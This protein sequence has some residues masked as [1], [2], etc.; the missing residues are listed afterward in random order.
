M[1]WRFCLFITIL[2]AGWCKAGAQELPLTHF[3]SDSEVNA[4]PSALVTNI[5]QDRQGYV[6]F[7]V[8]TSG[9]VRYDGSK[10]ELYDQSNGLR[11]LGIWQM[12]EDH[13][14][15]LWV[16]SGGGLVVSEK[17]LQEYTIGKKVKFTPLFKGMLLTKEAVTGNQQLALDAAGCVWLGTTDKGII[18]YHIDEDAGITADTMSTKAAGLQNLAVNSLSSAGKGGIIAGLEGGLLVE[19]KEDKAGILYGSRAEME[20][21]NFHAIHED[22]TGSIW[23]YRQNGDILYFKNRSSS[24]KIILS[25]LPS[26]VMHLSSLKDGTLLAGNGESGITRIN[27]KTGNIINSYS[28]SNGL[29]SNNVYHIL[30]DKEGNVWIAQSGGVSK[31]RYNF[32]AFENF[33][34][35]SVA[36]EKPVLP[37]GK[38]NAVLISETEESPCRFWVGTEGG[39]TCINQYGSSKFFTQADGLMGD[40]VNGLSIDSNG[41]IW[42]ATTQGINAIVFKKELIIEE[43]FNVRSLDIFG[44][45]AFIFSIWDS[46]GFIASENL[47]L[48][49]KKKNL[50]KESIWFPGMK[51]LY[52]FTEGKI[53]EFGP[54]QG[55]P[56]TL[57]KSVTM[58]DTGYLWVGTRDR[59]LYR[60]MQPVLQ[61]NLETISRSENN[62]FEQVWSLD[63]GAPTNHIEKLLWHKEKLWAGTQQGLFMLDPDSLKILNQINA[64]KGLPADN[65]VSFAVSPITQNFWIGTNKGLAEVVPENGKVL[66]VVTRQDG[67]IENEVWLYGSVK[68]DKTGKIYYGT[69][70]G[71]SI[72]S[73][74]KDKPNAVPPQLQLTLAEISYKSD[75]RNEVNFEYAALS[76]ANVADVKYRTRLLGYDN[77]WSPPSAVKRLR[78]TNLPA[79]LFPKEY[80]LE[81]TAEN[82]SGV[83][84]VEPLRHKFVV[85]PVW[86]LQW[87]AFLL[88]AI[89]FG[90][91]IF[92]VDRI[93]RR[94]LI[95]RERDNARLREAELQAEAA[96]ARSNASESQALALQAENEKKA[97][98]LEKVRELEK[99]Y[100]ELKTTQKQLI[101]A[102]KMAS[103]GRLAT[104]V[105]HEIKNPLNF[106]NNFAELSSELVQELEEARKTGDEEEIKFLM[107]DLKQNSKKIEEH[108]KRADAI[109]RSM[110]QHARG[111]KP[112]LEWFNINNL[113]EKYTDL[114]YQGKR[115]QYKGF[116]AH[117]IMNLDENIDEIK[118]VGQEIGQVLLNVIGNSLDAVLEKKKSY[119]GN[120]EPMVRIT[121]RKAGS[122]VEIIIE[123]NGPGIPEDIREKIF[124]PFF[125]TKPTGEGTGLGLSLSYNIITQG[126]NGSL[127]LVNNEREG[128]TF[129]IS[130]PI[131]KDHPKKRVMA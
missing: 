60:S 129:I 102:E 65:A 37:S 95:K 80:T 16:S 104:G 4:L 117:I 41:R 78:Y 36:G 114:A 3:T 77:S 22:E 72:Y 43:A 115:N 13:L 31:L 32:N 67:L 63:K 107:E 30:E 55:L 38:I 127:R 128:A 124:E 120:F 34:A 74:D 12:V 50:A 62:F 103:L 49:T 10:M 88:Y 61:E 58:D 84:V 20:D 73:P 28:R 15:Y 92:L 29:L 85:D 56:V 105:A 83:E 45:E 9:L 7:A 53:Y 123:D 64:S 33:S 54:Q 108:G 17:P 40:W 121:T 111:G 18:R 109:V 91:I 130:I 82:E 131:R 118:V 122:L 21:E 46:P 51:S 66:N 113:I 27:E 47:L 71:L 86:W 76:F 89:S 98:E 1:I 35:R 112:V 100:N 52:A 24:P 70:N 79:Y 14:G 8:F 59:G 5:Y 23:A 119:K 26:N 125:T 106:I 99:A 25:G 116:T 39:A 90:V 93:Q 2:L 48:K 57:Y 96:I 81:V 101:Q 110:M 94:R 44:R 19:F 68:V 97:L 42:I 69:S 87:W 6:W 11:D 75:S 126:H